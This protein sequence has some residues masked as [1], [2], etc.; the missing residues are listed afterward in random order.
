M[1]KTIRF[2]RLNLVNAKIN[3]PAKP[4]KFKS[5]LYDFILKKKSTLNLILLLQEILSKKSLK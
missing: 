3:Q 1:N 4:K 2:I 5:S